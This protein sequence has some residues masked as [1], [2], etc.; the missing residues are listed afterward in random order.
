M[1]WIAVIQL[2]LI[3]FWI[4]IN[5][6]LILT[7]IVLPMFIGDLQGLIVYTVLFRTLF[8]LYLSLHL[9][10]NR[11]SALGPM[12]FR[13]IPTPRRTGCQPVSMRSQS[14][15]SMTARVMS[16]ASSALMALR[17]VCV[18]LKTSPECSISPNPRRDTDTHWSLRVQLLKHFISRV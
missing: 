12:F 16:T 5:S 6:I 14:P 1:N 7:I 17:C 4:L 13:L 15:T 10:N 18:R 9:E 3:Q 8:F 11:S 2:I